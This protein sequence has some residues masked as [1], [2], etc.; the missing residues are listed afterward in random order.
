MSSSFD[1]EKVNSFPFGN[2]TLKWSWGNGR[3]GGGEMRWSVPISQTKLVSYSCRLILTRQTETV[4]N[5][6]PLSKKISYLAPRR[7]WVQNNLNWPFVSVWKVL[8]LTVH[9]SL[10]AKKHIPQVNF[11]FLPSSTW[12]TQRLLSGHAN[13]LSKWGGGGRGV[14]SERLMGGVRWSY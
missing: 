2:L 14:R 9:L 8:M 4:T 11:D 13:G 1:Q 12:W 5:F 3:G 10:S 6:P 7:F